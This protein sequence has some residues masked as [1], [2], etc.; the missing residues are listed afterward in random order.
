M[1]T[2]KD[3]ARMDAKVRRNATYEVTSAALGQAEP[4]NKLCHLGLMNEMCCTNPSSDS[5]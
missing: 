1:K 3:D 2:T 5:S 4:G